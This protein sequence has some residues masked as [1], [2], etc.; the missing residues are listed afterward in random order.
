MPLKNRKD[1]DWSLKFFN[2]WLKLIG[3]Q[4]LSVSEV[5][6]WSRLLNIITF[7]TV[8][9]IEMTTVVDVV[10]DITN[11]SLVYTDGVST[12][13]ALSWNFIIDSL[14]LAFYV[15][16]GYAVLLILTH[17]NSLKEL[18]NS[19]RQLEHPNVDIYPRFRKI[20]AYYTAY[21]IL[22]VLKNS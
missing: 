19:F 14:N 17:T 4:S 13:D 15:I 8:T 2:L 6:C 5:E 18:V 3:V 7:L 10:L 22:S 12:S 16:C 1:L 21:I 9:L 11:V 20:C